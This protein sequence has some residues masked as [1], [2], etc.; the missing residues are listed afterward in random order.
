ML[1]TKQLLVPIDF[2]SKEKKNTMEV[3]GN[4]QPCLFFICVHQNTF[5]LDGE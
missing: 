3:N 1:V 5:I 2:C 4:Q